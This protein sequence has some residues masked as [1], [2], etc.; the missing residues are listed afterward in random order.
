MNYRVLAAATVLCVT[1]AAFSQTMLNYVDP[2]AESS[3]RTRRST[4]NTGTGASGSA[5]NAKA[6]VTP[7]PGASPSPT[8]KSGTSTKTVS[9]TGTTSGTATKGTPGPA[10][11]KGGKPAT[12]GG[13]GGF[14]QQGQLKE[15]TK[16]MVQTIRTH[17][18][19]FDPDQAASD[20]GIILLNPRKLPPPE[21]QNV[22][23]D[24]LARPL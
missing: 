5:A 4:E 11:A 17:K 15:V 8:S 7:K 18:V 20:P 10:Q 14:Q 12:G 6:T 19:D 22:K 13:S 23:T 24:D 1:S 3:R 16:E 2:S 9:K 21:D